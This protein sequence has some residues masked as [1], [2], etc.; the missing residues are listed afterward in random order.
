MKGKILFLGFLS[1]LSTPGYSEVTTSNNSIEYILEHFNNLEKDSDSDLESLINPPNPGFPLM[2]CRYKIKTVHTSEC[3]YFPLAADVTN[4][5]TGDIQRKFGGEIKLTHNKE[6]SYYTPLFGR[7]R[8]YRRGAEATGRR[9]SGEPFQCEAGPKY[10]RTSA[11]FYKTN[12]DGSIQSK[13][14]YFTATYHLEAYPRYTST[15]YYED[16]QCYY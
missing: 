6:D 10:H 16:E 11:M 3:K 2:G 9:T 15:P 4:P 1:V 14:V 5:F 8:N 13:R 12:P 7:D